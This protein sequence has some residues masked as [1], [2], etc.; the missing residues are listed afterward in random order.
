LEGTRLQVIDL[1]RMAY[2]PALEIQRG[3]VEE[4][5]A[6]RDAGG[7][8]V[9]RVL[10]VEHDPVITVSRRAG[11]GTNLLATP[12]VLARHGVALAETDRGGDIT[13]HGPGQLVVYPILDLNLLNLGLH[14][15]MRMLEQVAIDVCAAFGAEAERDPSATGVWA[16]GA[17][18]CA[19]GVRVRR[20]VSMHGMA[21]NVTTNLEHFGLIVPCGLAGRRVTSLRELLGDGCPG[22]EEV[23]SVLVSDLRRHV[24][25]AR[26][27]AG[28]ARHKAPESAR[29]ADV[30]IP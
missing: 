4:V 26:D 24:E 9:G 19:M 17:K 3:H 12:E 30:P 11:A 10:L 29:S 18:V 6:A 1:G 8:E 28:R 21:L 22:M 27:E 25:R 7:A 20:W 13:Y 14:A 5:L 15:Y 23:K 2:G 16:Q